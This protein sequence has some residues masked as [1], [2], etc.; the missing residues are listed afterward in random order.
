MGSDAEL[1]PSLGHLAAG[2]K[3][4]QADNVFE[5]RQDAGRPVLLSALP[6]TPRE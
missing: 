1:L 6:M 5:D 2:V 3:E 4:E